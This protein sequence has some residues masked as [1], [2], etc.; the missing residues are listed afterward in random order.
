MI[1]ARGCRHRTDV[2]V[3]LA[4]GARLLLRE[5]TLF[6]RH[7]ERPGELRQRLRVEADGRPVHDQE[8][9]VGAPGWDGPAV[10]AGHRAAGSLL[11]ADPAGVPAAPGAYGRDAAAMPL[12]GGTGVLVGALAPDSA[13]LRRLLDAALADLTAP[14][15][16][17]PRDP[18][19]APLPDQPSSR[20]PSTSR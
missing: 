19:A 1:A 3:S 4:A 11:V 15:D 20:S 13:A 16:R 17:G 6:G 18:A 14:A 10:T 7:G 2:R 9:A 8:L 5:E 12:P